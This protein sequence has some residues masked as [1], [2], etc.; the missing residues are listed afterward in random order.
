MLFPRLVAVS[1][2]AALLSAGAFVGAAQGGE[3]LAAP[4]PGVTAEPALPE[5]TPAEEGVEASQS[6]PT[7]E[8][9]QGVQTLMPDMGGGSPGGC[10][11]HRAKIEPTV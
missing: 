4:L 8:E 7:S 1:A 10:P 9:P 3:A 11:H 6:V 5:S 2:I